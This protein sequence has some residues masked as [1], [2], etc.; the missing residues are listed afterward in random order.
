MIKKNSVNP[1]L[2]VSLLSEVVFAEC[3]IGFFNIF[4]SIPIPNYYN[5]YCGLNIHTHTFWKTI[6][7][8]QACTHL[9]I[10]RMRPQFQ[11]KKKGKSNPRV[12][13]KKWL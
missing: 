2:T 9:G 6:S 5:Y 13:A 11:V 7:G 1:I 12:S 4:D 10:K 8:N 3:S